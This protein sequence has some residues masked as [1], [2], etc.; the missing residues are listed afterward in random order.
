MPRGVYPRLPR[1]PS[2]PNKPNSSCLVC[3]GQFYCPPSRKAI[4]HGKYCSTKC[5]GEAKK[6]KK[7]P[8]L[9]YKLPKGNVPWNKGRGRRDTFCG[10]CGQALS[11]LD[12]QGG[13]G[14]RFCSRECAYN[15]AR[16]PDD[17][18]GYSGIH[19]RVRERYGAPS[20][21]EH[22]GT[23]DSPKF[24]WANISGEYRLDREDWARLCCQCHRRYD[25]GT[26][27]RIE[28]VIR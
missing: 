2:S 13:Q 16:L 11:V 5:M 18:L 26:V 10:N 8:N 19:N 21:C 7:D 1:K 20:E 6:G 3:G 28:L 9:T 12:S 23:T 27:N 17:Q 4:G 25:F 15:A 14:T 24:E 22:C